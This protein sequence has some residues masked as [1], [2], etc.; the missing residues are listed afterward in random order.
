MSFVGA[1]LTVNQVLSLFCWDDF[2]YVSLVALVSFYITLEGRCQPVMMNKT[3]H[4]K[5]R[6]TRFLFQICFS[7]LF[8]CWFLLLVSLLFILLLI[9]F[10]LNCDFL[11]FHQSPQ[12][13]DV[14]SC[15]GSFISDVS[16]D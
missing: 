15:V 2:V 12:Y 14:G 4:L 6:Y 7:Q 11:V 5:L 13:L 3:I 1:E 9:L 10:G 16:G 8:L